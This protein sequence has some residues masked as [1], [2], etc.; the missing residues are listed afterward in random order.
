[1]AVRVEVA[2]SLYAW[3]CERSERDLDAL[4]RTFPKLSEWQTGRCSPTLKQLEHFARA[5]RTPVGYFFLSTPPD[6]QIPIPDLQTVGGKGVTRPNPDLLDTIYQCQQRQ[7][8]Y[9]DY[10]RSVGAEAVSFVGSMSTD[11]PV[12]Q[13]ASTI[14]SVLSFSVDKR[15]S[16]CSEAFMSLR[17]RA[18][19]S[20]VLVMVNGVVGNNT[21]R[22]LDPDEFRGFALVDHLAPLVFVNGADSKA[23]QIFTLLHE[24][25]H[26]WLGETALSDVDL[27][28]QTT[29]RV[30]SWCNQVAAETLVPLEALESEFNDSVDLTAELPR[31]AHRFKSSTVVVLRRMQESGYLS[32]EKYRK[33]YDDEFARAMEQ[34][35]QRGQG[36]GNFYN[37]QPA[38]VSRLFARAVITSTL[39]G[40][41][42]YTDAFRMLG[43][44]KLATFNGQAERLG[45]V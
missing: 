15:G 39:E 41:T 42:L 27:S 3:A 37:T 45:I 16:S 8:W 17:D 22:K 30:E 14:T 19:D 20:G 25:A 9:R 33:A 32:W 43:F 6:E 21:S 28:V 10:A 23:A 2:P 44:K 35:G 26:I 13:A 40:Q 24:L 34:I 38:R 11:T 4:A 36:G 1:M 5:T 7:D 18:E 31:L 12:S 29:S